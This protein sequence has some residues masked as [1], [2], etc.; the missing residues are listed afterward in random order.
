MS[1]Q[2]GGPNRNPAVGTSKVFRSRMGVVVIAAGQSSNDDPVTSFQN[3]L[4]ERSATRLKARVA[5]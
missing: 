5:L 3:I 1:S 4:R 2:A